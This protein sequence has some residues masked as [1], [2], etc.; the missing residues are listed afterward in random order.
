MGNQCSEYIL[1]VAYSANDNVIGAGLRYNGVLYVT[2]KSDGDRKMKLNRRDING[3]L[4]RILKPIVVIKGIIMVFGGDMNEIVIIYA[5]NN[6]EFRMVNC[7]RIY[8]MELMIW[9][10]MWFIIE[11]MVKFIYF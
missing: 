7:K 3:K 1:D 4:Y 11:F 9:N 8:F 5:N 10:Q 2:N 6:G